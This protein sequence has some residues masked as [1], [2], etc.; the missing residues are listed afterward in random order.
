MSDLA[1]RPPVPSGRPPTVPDVDVSPERI[2]ALLESRVPL[3]LVA[4]LTAPGPTAA[5]LV[6]EEPVPQWP[7]S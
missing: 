7:R 2:R 4:D 3:A 5:R 1:A 6:R